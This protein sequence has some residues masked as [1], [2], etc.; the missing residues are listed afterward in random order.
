MGLIYRFAL[1]LK[2]RQSY[3]HDPEAGNIASLS[4]LLVSALEALP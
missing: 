2:V 4:L 3:P 1:F